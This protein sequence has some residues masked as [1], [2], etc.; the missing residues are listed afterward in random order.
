MPPATDF[1]PGRIKAELRNGVIID[2]D[3]EGYDD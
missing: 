1:V 3:L 2:V